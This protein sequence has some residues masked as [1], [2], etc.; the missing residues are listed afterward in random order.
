MFIG[1]LMITAFNMYFAISLFQQLLLIYNGLTFESISHQL[2]NQKK[3]NQ[4]IKQLADPNFLVKRI[5]GR[6]LS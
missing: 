6:F 4:A 1:P 2:I 3:I 5:L